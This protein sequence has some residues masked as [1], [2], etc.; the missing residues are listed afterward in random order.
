M[1]LYLLLLLALVHAD[2]KIPRLNKEVPNPT[3]LIH[4][5][6][7]K[8]A[9]LASTQLATAPG[10]LAHKG[11]LDDQVGLWKDAEGRTES[12][13]CGCEEMERGAVCEV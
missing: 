8:V 1:L 2:T 13:L 4:I 6:L 9:G 12:L 7:H 10:I 11:L 3:S 5:N